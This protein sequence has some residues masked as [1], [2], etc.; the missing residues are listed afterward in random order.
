[1][2]KFKEKES[3]T[4]WVTADKNRVPV[5]IKADL[6]VWSIRADLQSFKSLNNSFE[7]QFL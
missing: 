6:A 1:M 4:I 3:L 7:I 2:I 5:K